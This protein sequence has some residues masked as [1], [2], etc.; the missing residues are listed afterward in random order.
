[1]SVVKDSKELN[2]L[3]SEFME[4]KTE[5]E[6]CVRLV[7]EMN[8]TVKRTIEVIEKEIGV[9]EDRQTEAE[10]RAARE[11]RNYWSK[12]TNEGGF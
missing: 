8:E 1:M 6:K 3:W 2:V 5:L 11:I 12:Y 9:V 7:S 10:R 4:T